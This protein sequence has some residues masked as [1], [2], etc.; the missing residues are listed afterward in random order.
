MLF[1]TDD[2]R[3]RSIKELLPPVALLE[4]FP[5]TEM[6][7]QT[8]FS[9]RTAIHKILSGQDDRLLVIVGPCS[10]HDPNAAK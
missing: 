1:E 10:I 8:V 6:A 5:L 9:T 7:S 4:R 3:I 2:L